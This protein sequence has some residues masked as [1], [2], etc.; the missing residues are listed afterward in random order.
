MDLWLNDILS[1]WVILSYHIDIITLEVDTC[2]SEFKLLVG[3]N[4]LLKLISRCRIIHC[5]R[6]F[7]NYNHIHLLHNNLLNSS[8]WVYSERN[9]SLGALFI[10]IE[11]NIILCLNKTLSF[12]HSH[13]RSVKFCIVNDWLHDRS[14]HIHYN[15]SFLG[16]HIDQIV[17]PEKVNRP[18]C[19]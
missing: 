8:S 6:I 17:I 18:V 5:S 11:C 16:C 15:V 4:S 9:G 3:L 7:V 13:H 19:D 2:L 10:E 12:W 1:R 14:R